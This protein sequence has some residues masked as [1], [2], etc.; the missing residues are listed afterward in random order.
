MATNQSAR[1]RLS[2]VSMSATAAVAVILS[3]IPASVIAQSSAGPGVRARPIRMVIPFPPGNSGD[4]I[5]R[6]IMP[7]AT[8][9]MKHTIII[10]NR[11]GASG[12]IAAEIVANSAPDGSTLLFGT[13][14]LLAINPAMYSKLP[15][16]PVRDFAPVVYCAG[17][18]YT[19]V[20]SPSLP[21]ANLKE[22][23]ALAKA[24]PG[25]LNLGSTGAGTG[26]YLSG[27]LFNSR[28]GIKITHVPYKGATDALTDLIAGRIQVMFATTSSAVPY[29]QS[30]KVKA[31]AITG[32]ERD[33]ALPQLPT[34]LETGVADYSS[35][36]FFGVLAPKATPKAI[37]QRLNEA[38]VTALKSAE[39]KQRLATLGVNVAWSTPEEFGDRIKRELEKWTKTVRAIGVQAD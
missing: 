2:L 35:V 32:T 3:S 19:I 25:E 14:G 17:S 18:T 20:T 8:D 13:T 1:R 5:A 24:K 21:V 11:G 15:Y 31:L 22:F 37:V 7:T 23:V 10:D 16:H 12:A 6:A 28:A 29:V 38:F 39:V 30:N 9:V 26:M 27:V 33:P 36:S 34:V 4:I